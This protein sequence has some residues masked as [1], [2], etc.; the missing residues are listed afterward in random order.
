MGFLER[1]TNWNPKW[2]PLAD[3]TRHKETRSQ[4]ENAQ[5]PIR[6]VTREHRARVR[7]VTT[8]RLVFQE[9]R[10]SVL[11]NF[12]W[13]FSRVQKRAKPSND[14]GLRSEHQE[15]VMFERIHM[16]CANFSP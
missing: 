7:H 10:G 3:P 15:E 5:L 11:N 8:Q 14:K 13:E 16:L 4:K 6:E 1:V 9:V 2:F 12:V